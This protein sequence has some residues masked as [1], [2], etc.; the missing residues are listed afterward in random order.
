MVGLN[1]LEGRG[2]IR[3]NQH[4]EAGALEKRGKA[5]H[6]GVIIIGEENSHS[7]VGHGLVGKA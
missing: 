4:L 2:P 3:Y 1:F 5:V 7:I 6:N